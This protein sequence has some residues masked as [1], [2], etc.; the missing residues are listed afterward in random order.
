MEI[1]LPH[2]FKKGVIQEQVADADAQYQ[3]ALRYSKGLGVRQ[4]VDKA[5]KL[6]RESAQNGCAQSQFMMGV[7]NDADIGRHN[8]P[9]AANEWY[10][11]AG[12][13]GNSEAQFN[14]GY[15]Y[16]HGI[17]TEVNINEALHWYRKA[18]ARGSGKA[19]FCLGCLFASDGPVCEY[20]KG[21][22]YL[23]LAFTQG[24]PKAGYVLY[25]LYSTGVGLPTPNSFQAQKWLKK[26][27][28]AKVPAAM[29]V[30]GH[31]TLYGSDYVTKDEPETWRLMEAA[32]LGGCLPAMT[33]LGLMYCFGLAGKNP[34]FATAYSLLHT[35]S[36]CGDTSATAAVAIMRLRGL[37]ITEERDRAVDDCRKAAE[38]NDG[39]AQNNLGVLCAIGIAAGGR[40][41]AEKLFAQAS[42]NGC[43]RAAEN[44]AALDQN[45][46]L[47]FELASGSIT[48]SFPSDPQTEGSLAPSKKT[49]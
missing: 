14:L 17:G 38:A 7:L 35:A 47:F 46:P 44:R 37:G 20:E 48:L 4:D 25:A 49:A 15:N 39:C 2:L 24:M 36:V 16:E 12:N 30:L 6:F 27:A 28:A 3:L 40:E 26:A 21:Y 10:A 31:L 41:K 23:E 43:A 29:F 45:G 19:S 34:D 11:L 1:R 9:M 22:R 8:A 5:E 33:S 18:S 32:V 13:A 42:Q